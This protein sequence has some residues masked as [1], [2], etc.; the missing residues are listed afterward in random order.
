MVFPTLY[1]EV[2]GHVPSPG[3]HG[4]GSANSRVTIGADGLRSNGGPV[5]FAGQTI[6]A[7]G[8]SY[9]YGE[10]VSDTDTWP[11]YLQRLSGRRVLNGGVSGYGFDQIVLRAEHLVAT[12][13]PSVVI[14]GFIADD[15]LRTEMRRLWWRDKPWFTVEGTRL[16]LKGV[17]VPD[18][19]RLPLPVRHRI[20]QVLIGLPSSLQHLAGYHVRVHPAGTG[21]LIVEKLIKR[22]AALQAT[23]RA[24]IVVM[25]QYH[26][27]VWANKAFAS[28]HVR[29]TRAVLRCADENGL[30]IVDTFA[31]FAAEPVPRRFYTASHMNARGNRIVGGLLTAMLPTFT[32]A[33]EQW[34]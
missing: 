1:H 8:D 9:T 18:R 11:A 4:I 28:E 24:G 13:R 21:L 23:G 7:V 30:S 5:D 10:E 6:L 15:V 14:V 16:V 32:R 12:Y 3:F 19:A 17:P 22:L 33:V 2:L 25:A 29:L 34:S 20:E 26:P 31:R 27:A